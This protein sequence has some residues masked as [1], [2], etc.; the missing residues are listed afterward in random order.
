MGAMK[1]RSIQIQLASQQLDL[2][3][4]GW[5]PLHESSPLMVAVGPLN[6]TGMPGANRVVFYGHSPLT[7]LMAGT[8]MGGRFGN[9]LARTG[10]LAYALRGRA[11]EHSVLLVE[12]DSVEILPRPDLWGLKVSD[13]RERLRAGYPGGTAV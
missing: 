5:E 1:E 9:A 11:P 3:E 12:D 7:G 8:W 2:H 10:T 4:D 6:A 13:A